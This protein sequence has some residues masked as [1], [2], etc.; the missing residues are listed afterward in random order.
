MDTICFQVCIHIQEIIFHSAMAFDKRVSSHNQ[1]KSRCLN[2]ADRQ[3][4]MIDVAEKTRTVDAQC[5]ICHA[6]CFCRNS[7]YMP[8][9]VIHK[10]RHS[11][12]KACFVQGARIQS[13]HR[14][15]VMM[16]FQNFFNKQLALII[17][18]AG[19]NYRGGFFQEHTNSIQLRSFVRSIVSVF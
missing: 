5:K 18:V 4:G 3:I 17:N 7:P 13:F 16:P 12:F 10:V 11:F 1:S 15:S 8:R 6:S 19:N 2:A 14:T 9:R